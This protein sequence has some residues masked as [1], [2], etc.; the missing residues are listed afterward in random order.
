MKIKSEIFKEIVDKNSTLT[1]RRKILFDNMRKLYPKG[2][3]EAQEK[4][5]LE[6]SEDRVEHYIKNV[7]IER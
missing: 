1:G 3:K 6:L 5:C 7:F 2:K 4:L